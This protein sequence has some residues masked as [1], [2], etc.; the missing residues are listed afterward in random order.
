MNRGTGSQ[1][2]LRSKP[3]SKHQG[4]A[5]GPDGKPSQA[6]RQTTHQRLMR[7][8]GTYQR[9]SHP[10][11]SSGSDDGSLDIREWWKKDGPGWGS[12]NPLLW[13]YYGYSI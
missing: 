6:N 3:A 8:V 13:Q 2:A 12:V 11:K 7:V 9:T 10:L 1:T 4:A 5:G